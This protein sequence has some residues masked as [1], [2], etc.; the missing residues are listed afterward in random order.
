MVAPPTYTADAAA[1]PSRWIISAPEDLR[2]FIGS[3]VVSYA[4]LGLLQVGLP[5]AVLFLVW[6]IFFDGTHIFGTVSRTYLDT[7]ERHARAGLLWGSLALFALGPALS[8]AGYQAQL[9]L[10]VTLWSYHHLVAQHYGFM[11]LYKKKNQDLAR[12]DNAI[13][14]AFLLLGSWYP[15]LHIVLQP[16][17]A[18]RD[19]SF[20]DPQSAALVEGV[21]WWGV[22]LSAAVF[23]A[24]Q[25]QKWL[26][27]EP[28]D[29]PKLLLL[30]AVI[31]LPWVVFAALGH[32]PYPFG[33][34]L[35]TPVLSLFH[36]LQY[37]RLVW[38]YNRNKY[39][40]E[41]AARHHG[42]AAT[43]NSRFVF[44]GIA[45]V[46]FSCCYRLPPTVIPTDYSWL[47]SA[48]TG[49]AL[50]HYFLDGKIWRVRS[51]PGLGASLR[52]SPA[53]APVG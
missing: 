25:L 11:V 10:L 37:H 42:W 30:A 34:L 38:F 46:I 13:D 26:C 3:V 27:D 28:L 32:L 29:G 8:L 31:P 44:Y 43:I 50:I 17:G 14:R 47:A 33:L 45:A 52:M 48:F 23:A 18:T 2:W 41:N 21:M 49:C 35:S 20:V 53:S 9:V 6:G 4:V 19:L 15:Y 16:G 22:L 51:D 36:N 7:E 1:A 5:A 39:G 24:R 40:G 12:L